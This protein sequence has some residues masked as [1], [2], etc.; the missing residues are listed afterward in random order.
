MLDRAGP[1]LDP[2]RVAGR[3][4]GPRPRS[5][6]GPRLII[7]SGGL[8]GALE[9]AARGRASSRLGRRSS[10]RRT[11]A[12]QELDYGVRDRH[13][14]GRSRARPRGAGRLDLLLQQAR[15]HDRRT[16]CLAPSAWTT[17][18]S[19]RGDPFEPSPFHEC[20]PFHDSQPVPRL[21]PVRTSS[22]PIAAYAYPG[23]G[24]RQPVAY[25]GPPPRRRRTTRSRAGAR[26]SP[27]STPGAAGT[28]GSTTSS[29]RTSSST[30]PI[31]YD[32]SADRPRAG[33]RPVGPLD[34]VIDALSGHG[35]FIAG[36][37]HQ[38][39]PD[40]DIVRLAGRPVRRDRSSSPT[41]SRRS[42]PDRRAGQA[43]PRRRGRRAPDRRAE[44]VDGL[45]PRD[46]R[47]RAC[48][49]PT[50]YEILDDLADNGTVVVC[51]AGN[52]ATEPAVLP[53]GVQPW[54]T[55]GRPTTRRCRWSRWAHSTPTAHRALFS[56]TGP[57]VAPT[58]PARPWS[59][60]C[61]RS[62]AGSSRW[63]HRRLRPAARG[64]RPRRLPRRVRRVERDVV[65]RADRR[66]ARSPPPGR[67]AVATAGR[68]RE[69]RD[70]ARAATCRGPGHRTPRPTM[71]RG[72]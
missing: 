68:G 45:L 56:N 69:Q 49:D 4:V 2:H 60:R 24:G 58:R 65:R 35:T 59:A 64:D 34:G 54:S 33:R 13:D 52:D 48:F 5:Y 39:C 46:A 14:R 1:V 43:P 7:P 23:A 53:G 62:R 8:E 57:W 40:A 55:A 10:T 29:R 18:C 22:S 72:C 28:R 32:D 30:T 38:A 9:R 11:R 15:A 26:W 47:G 44:P 27:S 67:Q 61:P 3:G 6:V 17:C 71:M 21:Q 20:S 12:P 41:W 25:V 66:R 50:M 51:S 31:G 42:H 19:A 36:L 63:P 37:V 70:G 16:T